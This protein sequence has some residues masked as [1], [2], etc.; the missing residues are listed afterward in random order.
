MGTISRKVYA[1]M[2]AILFTLF[3]CATPVFAAND[4]VHGMPLRFTVYMVVGTIAF[5]VILAIT[6]THKKSS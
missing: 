5:I 6:T 4:S 1:I 3:S 2:L